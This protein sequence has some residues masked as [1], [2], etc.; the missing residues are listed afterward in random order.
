[1]K[2]SGSPIRSILMPV[3]RADSNPTSPGG[4]S[5][6]TW[7]LFAVALR[8]VFFS[9]LVYGGL[10]VGVFFLLSMLD[11]FVDVLMVVPMALTLSPTIRALLDALNGGFAAASCRGLGQPSAGPLR[12][13]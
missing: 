4:V 2:A 13:R 9:T 8:G 5:I 10:A 6:S 3:N 12:R 11:D 1:M 7:A